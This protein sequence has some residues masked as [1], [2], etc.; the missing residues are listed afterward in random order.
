MQALTKKGA[1][2]TKH[3]FRRWRSFCQRLQVHNLMEYRR[4]QAAAVALIQRC[5][6]GR[7]GRMHA[8]RM[9][10]ASRT[11]IMQVGRVVAGTLY[12]VSIY[13]LPYSSTLAIEMLEP[14]SSMCYKLQVSKHTPRP[15][16]CKC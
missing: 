5:M 9:V 14:A 8:A 15:S 16:H 2:L 11:T 4:R 7:L 1:W 12:V 10:L 3:S 6:R 13:Q